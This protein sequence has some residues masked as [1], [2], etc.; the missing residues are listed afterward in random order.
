MTTITTGNT[1]ATSFVVTGDTTGDMILDAKS[2]IISAN[3]VTGG[4]IL[5]TGTAGQRPTAVNGMIR[6]SSSANAFEMYANGAWAAANVSPVPV[7]TVAPVVSG[8]AANGALLSCTTGTWNNSPNTY[9]YQ[10]SANSVAISGSTSSTLTLGASQVNANITCSVT[11]Q[12]AA[13]NSIPAVSNSVG[14]IANSYL[15]TK[16]LRFRSSASAYLNR[17]LSA[18]NR[19]TFTFNAWV[20]KSVVGSST[21]AVLFCSTDN[22]TST[23]WLHFNTGAYGSADTL[24]FEDQLSG[25]VLVTSQVFRD[26]SAWYMI[27]LSID[28]TQATASNRARLFVNGTQVTAFSTATYPSQNAD[29]NFNRTTSFIHT[30]GSQFT[31]NRFFNG[32]LAEV[33]FIDGQALTPSSFGITD[34]NTG[35]WQPIRYAGTYGTNGFYLPFTNTTSTTT[36][37]SDSSGNNNNWTPNNISL[38]AGVTYDSMTD[39]PT[40]T[41]TN[42]GN[43]AV[44][45]P[46]TTGSFTTL[47]NGNLNTL[48]NTSS[49]NGNS[50]SSFAMLTGKWYLEVTLTANALSTYPQFGIMTTADGNRPNNGGPQAGYGLGLVNPTLSVA[51]FAN[52]NKQINN[53][54]TSYGN[55]Y[56][57][58]DVIGIAIDS[59]N[60]AIYFS[61]NGTFQNSGV[62]T[63]GSSKTGAALTWTGGTVEHLFSIA[64]YNG[65]ATAAN[66]GQRP[67]SYTPPTG[68]LALNTSNLPNPT[69]GTSSATRANRYFDTS[70]YTGTGSALSVTNGGFQPDFIW[71]KDRSTSNYA[72]YLTDAIRGF[73]KYLFSNLTNSEGTNANRVTSVSSTGFTIGTDPAVNTNGS[74]HVAWNW[75]AGGSNATNTSGT[76]TSTVRANQTAGFSIVSYAS[77]SAGQKTVGHGLGV[78]PSMIITKSRDNNSY[79]WSIYHSSVIDTTSKFLRFT[80]DAIVTSSTIW[81]AAL[82][83]STVFG[84]TSDNGVPA[85]NNCI[86]YCWTPVAGYS[87]FGSYTGNGSSDG[88]FVFLGF[89]PRFIMWKR[90]DST[91]DW[92]IFDTARDTYNYADKQLVPNTGGAEQVTGGGFVREDFLSNG[93]KVRSTDSYINANGGT[94]IYAAFAESPFKFANA[95]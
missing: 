9:F 40:N 16:S 18:S 64:D 53:S 37:V 94:Y 15:L 50:R 4:M 29:T 45:N 58:G 77:G 49:N 2:G 83:T 80:T 78:T 34:A 44:M 52:G 70:L 69:V 36:L 71:I 20:K 85:N 68:F 59:D 55:S 46:L 27:T 66:F 5:P 35:V 38:T 86:A 10:W 43:Y 23:G 72:H 74:A 62:P 30:I 67:F 41:N 32:Y 8:A 39:V 61:K 82:P 57:N 87:A 25:T 1:V 65:T 13:G 21:G 79:N 54:E 91:G 76:I 42:T 31:N 22:T 75:N 92:I 84:I 7:N 89:R 93:F 14:P 12:N 33:N 51:Y 81:G 47:S 3:T 95:R 24:T 6:Y 19:K 63:S 56:T 11:A 60:G 48:G 73:D 90:S 28:T 88:P 26:P 17:T